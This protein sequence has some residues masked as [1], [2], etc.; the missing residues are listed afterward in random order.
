[1]LTQLVIPSC[2]KILDMAVSN[3]SEVFFYLDFVLSSCFPSSDVQGAA[4]I[5]CLMLYAYK[6]QVGIQEGLKMKT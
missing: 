3:Y 1:M 2:L 5:A 6:L 4:P